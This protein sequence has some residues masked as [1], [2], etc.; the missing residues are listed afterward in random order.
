MW[1]T[2]VLHSNPSLH[3]EMSCEDRPIGSTAKTTVM[4]LY[5]AAYLDNWV[6]NQYSVLF[7][8]GKFIGPF[9]NDN[10]CHFFRSLFF[11]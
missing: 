1:T 3:V 5:N 8:S 10:I 7:L 11:K 2:K 6:Y 9:V 4:M